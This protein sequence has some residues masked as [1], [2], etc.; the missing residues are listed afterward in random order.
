M[1]VS[2]KAATI[3]SVLD[4]SE[5]GVSRHVDTHTGGSNPTLTT[6]LETSK[7]VFSFWDRDRSLITLLGHF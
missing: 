5:V 1:I 4:G 6:L 2:Q 7:S 3:W